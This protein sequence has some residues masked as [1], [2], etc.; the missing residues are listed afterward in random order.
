MHPDPRRLNRNRVSQGLLLIFHS[1]RDIRPEYQQI[2]HAFHPK[3]S[4]YN[5][6]KPPRPNPDLPIR[7]TRNRP[8]RHRR[9][10]SPNR[11]LFPVL[12]TSLPDPINLL[13]MPKPDLL[14]LI[15]SL[16]HRITLPSLHLLLATEYPPLHDHLL[17]ILRPKP[18]FF[19]HCP[20][21]T[22]NLWRLYLG[23]YDRSLAPK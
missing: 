6:S 4:L 10:E 23:P 17:H 13:T 22:G 9:H 2:F 7:P 19:I 8:S 16:H 5:A 1:G 15:R 11:L 21:S 18:I 14:H 12:L 20:Q 3:T